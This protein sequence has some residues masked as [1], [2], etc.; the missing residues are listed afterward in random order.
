MLTNAQW[1]VIIYTV[2][3][4]Y[5]L[6]GPNQMKIFKQTTSIISIIFALAVCL[7]SVSAFI[8]ALFVIPAFRMYLG[9]MIVVCGATYLFFKG[10]FELLSMYIDYDQHRK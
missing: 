8:H 6:K 4:F 1:C 5:K 2:N 3:N 7:F 9:Q 10:I